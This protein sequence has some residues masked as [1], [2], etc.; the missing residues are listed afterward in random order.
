MKLVNSI[1]CH[2]LAEIFEAKSNG[3]ISLLVITPNKKSVKN[4][5]GVHG[6]II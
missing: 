2:S 3:L 1:Y 4:A 5:Y 6:I